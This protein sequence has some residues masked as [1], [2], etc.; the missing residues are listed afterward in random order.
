MPHRRWWVMAA[1]LGLSAALASAAAGA[2]GAPAAPAAVSLTPIKHVVFVYNENHSFDNIFGPYCATK[3]RNSCTGKTGRV[4]FADGTSANTYK[5]KD[6]VPDVC[7][8]PSCQ[9]AAING[10]AMNGWNTVKGCTPQTAYACLQQYEPSQISVLTAIARNGVLGDRFFSEPNPSAGSHMFFFTGED[11]QGFTGAIP[12]YTPP[13]YTAHFGWGCD[14]NKQATWTNPITGSQRGAWFCNPNASERPN[15]GAPGPTPVKPVPDFFTSILD[16]AGVSWLNYGAN[17]NV[18]AYKYNVLTYQAAALYRDGHKS[19][20]QMRVLSDARAGKLPN[21]SFVTSAG[22]EL[23]GGGYD[24]S[25]HNSS[26]MAVGNNFIND[27]LAAI[28]AGPNAL[29]TAVLITYDDCGCFYDHIAPGAGLGPRVPLLIW[30]PW[31]RKGY[32]DHQPARFASILAFIEANFGLKS[33]TLSNPKALDGV[34]TND[35]MQD[36]NFAQPMQAAQRNLDSFRLPPHD[37]VSEETKEWLREHAHDS[38]GDET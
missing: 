15:G 29:N 31:A 21:V 28:K 8:S 30:S 33:L 1:V 37:F 9:Q 36:F 11:S 13:G 20:P 18:D 26:S 38:D 10:G 5:A 35:L 25:Q 32:V 12:S 7:H 24:T 2:P 23:V 27:L 16:P 3:R 6:I 34:V 14:S 17:K 4:T 22:S 19:V